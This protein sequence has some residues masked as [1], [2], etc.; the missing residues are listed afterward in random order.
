MRTAVREDKRENAFV[1][2]ARPCFIH[3][4]MAAHREVRPPSGFALHTLLN[5]PWAGDGGFYCFEVYITTRFF[6]YVS[7]NQEVSPSAAR[8]G[9][10]G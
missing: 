7:F 4:H 3:T 5:P 1:Y 6:Y 9:Q 8:F 10:S 2:E